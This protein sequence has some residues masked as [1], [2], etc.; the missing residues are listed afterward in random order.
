M[1]F[2]IDNSRRS[3]INKV[4]EIL[5]MNG[6]KVS[7]RRMN[8]YIN[9][10]KEKIYNEYIRYRFREFMTENFTDFIGY[11]LWGYLIEYFDTDENH[12]EYETAGKNSD[13]F[14]KFFF[15]SRYVCE[16]F[17]LFICEETR[18]K[19]Y[20]I[21]SE[22]LDKKFEGSGISFSFSDLVDKALY[23][24]CLDYMR[25]RRTKNDL[26]N[27]QNMFFELPDT[28]E[29]YIMIMKGVFDRVYTELILFT[30]IPEV[31]DTRSIPD[32]EKEAR[33]NYEDEI[34]ALRKQNELLSKENT[35]LKKQADTS[36][37]FEEV[38]NRVQ[39]AYKDCSEMI[40]LTNRKYSKL[41]N[42]YNALA[43]KYNALSKDA[44][45]GDYKDSAEPVIPS[46][47]DTNKRYV[48]IVEED[49]GFTEQIKD[50][51]PNA[52]FSNS[53]NIKE[54]NCDLVVFLTAFVSHSK[55]LNI[56]N[57]CKSNNI[58]FVHCAFTN[59]EMIKN[60]IRSIS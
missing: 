28:V 47:I 35:S 56:K 48:F 14:D 26:L 37:T 45:D 38:E 42:K 6:E 2:G 32:F 39:D 22:P 31:R 21:L 20:E 8:K 55:Y 9:E 58:P 18:K 25:Y 36:I 12:K 52:V 30:N 16:K 10:V 4:T 40:T 27:E 13:V 29:D 24:V 43:E 17:S 23:N 46:E 41:L 3:I 19:I 15:I 49:V 44:A 57:Q 33:K 5:V 34:D 7:N 1:N 53:E 60:A 50:E 11:A 51:F 54:M 59:V